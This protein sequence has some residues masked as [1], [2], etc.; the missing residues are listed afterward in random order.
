MGEGYSIINLGDISKPATVLIEKISNAI[1]G[2]CKPWQIKRVA[3][4]EVEAEIIKAEGEIKVTEIHRRALTR[5]MDEEAKKQQN[6]ETITEKALP[7][8]ADSSKPQEMDDD[9]ITNFF[10]KCRIVSDEQMQILWSKVLAGEANAPGSFS[11]R[12]VNLLG[13]LDKYDARLFASLCAFVWT[14]EGAMPLIYD[15]KASIY[16]KAGIT[17]ETL[18]HL[19][20]IGLINFEALTGFVE[21]THSRRIQL[22]YYGQAIIVEFT[23]DD[24]D[25]FV[26]GKVL[27]TKTGV[28]LA[29]VCESN[30]V[31]GFMDYVLDNWAKKGLV[32]ACPYPRNQ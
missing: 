8:L 19:G 6:I 3:K 12:T 9:W 23:G 13:S 2:S 1:G 25:G 15:H 4:A 18:T 10:D 17:F 11:K 26:V 28:Q 20:D 14:F 24:N 21:V 32:L 16:K 31:E 27:L 22:E 30:P 29:H 5:F 7:L